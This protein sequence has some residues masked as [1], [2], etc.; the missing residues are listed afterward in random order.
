M[1]RWAANRH[2]RTEGSPHGLAVGLCAPP[3]C[4]GWRQAQ[5]WATLPQQKGRSVLKNDYP[6]ED[7]AAR[8]RATTP[9]YAAVRQHPP[10]GERK[11]ADIV[12]YQGGRRSRDGGQGRVKIQ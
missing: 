5:G 2:H 11:L 12:R 9:G 4:R 3:G 1:S 6:A 7:D 10:R 8:A